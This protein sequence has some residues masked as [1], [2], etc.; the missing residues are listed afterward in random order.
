MSSASDDLTTPLGTEREERRPS[1]LARLPLGRIASGGAMTLAALIGGYLALVDDPSGGDPQVVVEIREGA[2]GAAPMPVD[3]AGGTA[4]QSGL[5]LIQ[6]MSARGAGAGTSAA[7][8]ERASGV[9]VT[10]PGGAAEPG[11]LII[12]VPPGEGTPP[13]PAG[14]APSGGLAPAPDQ[15]LVERTRYGLLPRVGED[16]AMPARVYARP[17][18]PMSLSESARVAILVTG[19]GIS[20]SGTTRAV[21]RLPPDVSLAFAPYGGDL[22]RHVSR[23]REDGHE[24]FLQVPMEPFD[25]P[26]SDPGPHTLTT[27]ASVEDNRDRLHWVMGRFTGYVGVVNFMGAKLTGDAASLQPILAEIGGRGLAYVDDGTS[28][29]SRAPALAADAGLPVA[30]GDVVLDTV[31]DP[32]RIDA[33]LSRLERLAR[34][35]GIA[36]ATASALPM[37]VDRIA[38]WAAQA[39]QRGVRLVPVSAALATPGG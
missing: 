14:A 2:P 5:A 33:E 36:V 26:R 25:Y 28:S 37:T 3:P 30:V 29:R 21:D 6:D 22:D 11:A 4:P 18:T 10:R 7:E 13:A 20:Q 39:E 31:P 16:G 15:R 32:D 24:V 34:E 38:A 19:L 27:E 23:A 17:P 9:S 8:I 12:Q 1:L 35:R